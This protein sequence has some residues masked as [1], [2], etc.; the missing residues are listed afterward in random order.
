MGKFAL[1]VICFL[2]SAILAWEDGY[3]E[4]DMEKG[5]C[6]LEY[7]A[8]TTTSTHI[9]VVTNTVNNV[10]TTTSAFTPCYGVGTCY[11]YNTANDAT[12]YLIKREFSYPPTAE[13][14]TP[15]NAAYTYSECANTCALAPNQHFQYFSLTQETGITGF[16]TPVYVCSCYLNYNIGTAIPGTCPPIV[17]PASSTAPATSATYNY[18][19]L[20]TNANGV[21]IGGTEFLIP[22]TPNLC[23]P[24]P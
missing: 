2:I 3:E 14:S 17:I 9:A 5:G 7:F 21:I 1:L 16:S 22:L 15:T 24:P 11:T 20:I 23:P 18:G 8:V 4:K 13:T 19:L 10:V 6:K 12:N